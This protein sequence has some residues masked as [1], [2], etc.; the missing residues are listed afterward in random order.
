MSKEL[1]NLV[2]SAAKILEANQ[3]HIEHN[4]NDKTDLIR[5][6]QEPIKEILKI[7]P[8]NLDSSAVLK[9]IIKE[10]FELRDS[11][12]V[13]FR[14]NHLF[15][16]L[17]NSKSAEIGSCDEGTI[18]CRYNGINESELESFYNNFFIKDIDTH[19]FYNTAKE[20]VSTY[21]LSKKINN[22]TYEKYVFPL[23]QSIIHNSLSLIF[24]KSGEFFKGFS[25]YVFRIHFKEVFEHITEIIL[26]ELSISN[27][28]IVEFLKYY[29]QGVISSD[30][31][32][33]KVPELE[34]SSGHKWSVTSMM[35]IVKIYVKA[36]NN[37]EILNQEL[38]PLRK[39]L[40]KQH[41]DS[42]SPV[43]Y[44]SELKLK[45]EKINFELQ[46]LSRKLNSLVLSIGK[47]KSKTDSL[48]LQNEIKA[49]RD[50]IGSLNSEKEIY[51]SKLLP[52][53]I[54][55]EYNETKK[56][57]TDFQRAISRDEKIL[58]LNQ[59]AYISIKSTLTK[60]LTSKKK[61]F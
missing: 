2:D 3:K 6:S 31:I 26:Y 22:T 12:I 40:A 55:R 59:D 13:F 30:G 11:D 21:M 57:V 45:I 32:K 5:V 46:Y 14:Q 35:S 53:N 18:A 1:A 28:Y 9:Q 19:F 16:K 52:S 25:G 37:I 47:S 48:K 33:Y 44:N 23:I 39:D 56:Q 41:I 20:F 58:T 61:A 15:I 24:D 34:A 8:K 36:R 51:Q 43:E 49:I 10:V 60:A 29:S 4:Y 38:E 17:F 54:L 27:K 7:V 50:S 42:I